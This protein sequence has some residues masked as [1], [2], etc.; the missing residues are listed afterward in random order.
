MKD[1]YKHYS[2]WVTRSLFKSMQGKH[3]FFK[4][5]K[6]NINHTIPARNNSRLYYKFKQENVVVVV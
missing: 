4:D 3:S 5:R 2:I 6:F 1:N